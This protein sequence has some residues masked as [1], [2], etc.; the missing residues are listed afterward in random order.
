MLLGVVSGVL[1]TNLF[2]FFL[3]RSRGAWSRT[4]FVRV[5]AWG[6]VLGLAAYNYFALRLPGADLLGPLGNW[7]AFLTTMLGGFIGLFLGWQLSDDG[8]ISGH[9]RRAA[10]D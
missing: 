7:A 6:L 10:G 9:R 4:R 8:A 2:G 5:A 3:V 1:V